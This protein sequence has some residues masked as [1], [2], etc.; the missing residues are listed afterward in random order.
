MHAALWMSGPVA[1][2]QPKMPAGSLNKRV[3]LSL[4]TISQVINEHNDGNSRGEEGRA[5]IHTTEAIR[6]YKTT[7][8]LVHLF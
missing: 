7:M 3:C 8:F 2:C 1:P 5:W 6:D 4:K